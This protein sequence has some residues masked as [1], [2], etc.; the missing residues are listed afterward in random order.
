MT[1][2]VVVMVVE[3]MVIVVMVVMVVMV[4]VLVTIA[5]LLATIV[6]ILQKCSI[7][8]MVPRDVSERSG[9]APPA[10]VT[11]ST[12]VSVTYNR[13]FLLCY[14]RD[15]LSLWLPRGLCRGHIS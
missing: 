2:T 13:L 10:A 6:I 7:W 4:M 3:M 9:D 12:F 15:S 11:D 14:Q 8:E 1:V 5:A